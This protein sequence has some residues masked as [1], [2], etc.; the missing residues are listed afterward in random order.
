VKSYYFET[1]LASP[2]GK[3][4]FVRDTSGNA[5]LFPVA[6]GPP[7]DVAGWMPDDVWI[8][9]AKDG[10][11]AYVFHDEQSSANVYR[12]DVTTGKRGFVAKLAPADTAGVTSISS[13]LYTPD[14][15]AYAYSGTQELSE[16]F[17]VDG[18]R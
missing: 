4:L 18:V 16:L 17:I 5:K 15:K 8:T 7:Q 6:G 10:K 3:F 13:V 9:W 14:G 2:D 11:Q 12:L 1:H